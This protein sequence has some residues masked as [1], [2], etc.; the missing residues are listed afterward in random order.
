M[1]LS[2]V[3]ATRKA[4]RSRR[5]LTR[6]VLSARAIWFRLFEAVATVKRIFLC[7]CWVSWSM[8]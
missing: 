7:C 3:M 8:A 6:R 1:R 2:V 5:S 4:S